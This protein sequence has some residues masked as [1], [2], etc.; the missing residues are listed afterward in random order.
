M[1]RRIR[2]WSV[3][4]IAVFTEPFIN[5]YPELVNPKIHFNIIVIYT[6]ST[7]KSPPLVLQR[8]LCVQ[9]KESPTCHE[10]ESLVFLRNNMAMQNIPRSAAFPQIYRKSR[11]PCYLTRMYI[12]SVPKRSIIST[13]LS[14]LH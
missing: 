2:H 7:T 13:R 3:F 4:L 1:S 8:S 12:R 6:L 5:Q 9:E 10:R 11:F 14:L